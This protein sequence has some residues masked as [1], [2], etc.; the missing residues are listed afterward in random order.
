M[1]NDLVRVR[2]ALT[3][4]DDWNWQAFGS[5]KVQG[6]KSFEYLLGRGTSR[7]WLEAMIPVPAPT[8]IV[9]VT[10]TEVTE[11]GP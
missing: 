5:S 6:L 4:D 9:E 7:Y 2:I 11:A 1:S 10:V 3:M 8:E